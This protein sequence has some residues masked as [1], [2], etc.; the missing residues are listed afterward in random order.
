[1]DLKNLSKVADSI[2]MKDSASDNE[3]L[4]IRN[5]LWN[6]ERVEY[7]KH[8]TDEDKIILK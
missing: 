1:M 8:W 3:R 5:K 4:E 6:W 7:P 2:K